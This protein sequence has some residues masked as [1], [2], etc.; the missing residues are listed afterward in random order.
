V[1][2]HISSR[3]A[4]SQLYVIETRLRLPKFSGF[5]WV[6]SS[7]ETPHPTGEVNFVINNRIAK[8]EEWI[9]ASFIIDAPLSASSEKLKA[10]FVS[11]ILPGQGTCPSAGS[12]RVNFRAYAQILTKTPP[13]L[14]TSTPLTSPEVTPT[15]LD[16]IRWLLQCAC[17][18]VI[19]SWLLILSRISQNT[20]A[21]AIC[22]QMR[23]FRMNLL[24]LERCYSWFMYA[25]NV[26]KY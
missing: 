2:T 10:Y 11:I 6:A 17:G 14:C 21:S 1:Q 4:L 3:S 18:V 12:Q 20:S 16:G 5:R 19:C 23:I 8:L 7:K 22:Q 9:K 26:I 25:W 15:I 13:S 24:S